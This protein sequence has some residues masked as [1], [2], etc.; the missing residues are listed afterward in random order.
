MNEVIRL[1]NGAD[2]RNILT[3]Q[4]LE[5]QNHPFHQNQDIMTFSGFMKNEFD[6]YQYVK[7]QQKKIAA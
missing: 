2:W 1:G 5:I 4:L 3:A 7:L 6:L